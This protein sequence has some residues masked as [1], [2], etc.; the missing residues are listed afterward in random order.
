MRTEQ[1]LA[2]QLYFCYVL[3]PYQFTAWQRF[4]LFFQQ[5]T[6]SKNMVYCI[7]LFRDLFTEGAHW[8]LY[9]SLCVN[10]NW[11]KWFNLYLVLNSHYVSIICALKEYNIYFPLFLLSVHFVFNNFKNA[12]FY[13]KYYSVP[14][15]LLRIKCW[16]NIL[17]IYL[18]IVK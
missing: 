15:V 17:Q 14:S 2:I 10:N 3:V 16:T 18:R 8:R 11:S 7:E 5:I 9:N 6:V 12:A 13:F 4:I 1:S